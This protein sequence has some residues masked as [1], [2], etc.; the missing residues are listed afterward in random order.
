[1]SDFR[2]DL[3]E[4]DITDSTCGEGALFFLRATPILRDLSNVIYLDQLVSKPS[5]CPWQFL[6][7]LVAVDVTTA[8]LKYLPLMP[9]K[10]IAACVCIYTAV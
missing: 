1:M 7:S 4:A 9:Q 2:Q 8:A 5:S 3:T 10:W 6:T